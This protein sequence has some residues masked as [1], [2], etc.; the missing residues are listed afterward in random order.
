MWNTSLR[1]LMHKTAMRHSSGAG[2]AG[3]AGDGGGHAFY[4]GGYQVGA[5]W[6]WLWTI[7]MHKK[8][9]IGA[10]S[11]LLSGSIGES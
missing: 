8:V 3:F 11:M 4:C 5:W 6:N 2:F 9:S 1:F 7:A 10:G